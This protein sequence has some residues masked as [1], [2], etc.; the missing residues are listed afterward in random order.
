MG[1]TNWSPDGNYLIANSGGGIYKLV[2]KPDG[3]VEPQRLA[4]PANFQC[5]NDKAISP[6]GK[7]IAFS[8]TVPPHK[9]SQVFLAD[10][11]GSNVKL[12]A[13]ESPSYFH[14]WSP[15]NKTLA[16]VA[17]RNGSGQFDI[18]SMPAEGAQRS[19]SRP[20]FTMTT[21]RTIRQTT[22]GS[23]STPIDPARKRSGVSPSMALVP[24]MRRPRWL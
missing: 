16:F 23:T 5:N 8:A 10:A 4:V 2:L 13:P 20:I 3:M 21:A 14:G 24:T 11:D 6:D 17:Q 9:G 1:G 22:S 18:Y 19:S 7:K 12:V 15:D